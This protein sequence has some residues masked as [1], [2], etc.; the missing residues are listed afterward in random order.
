[1]FFTCS[2]SYSSQKMI[3]AH[4]KHKLWDS[5]TFCR[6]VVFKTVFWLL[7]IVFHFFNRKTTGSFLSE[8]YVSGSALSCFWLDKVLC[9]CS[10]VLTIIFRHHQVALNCFIE[11]QLVRC[12]YLRDKRK[13][14]ISSTSFIS[15]KIYHYSMIEPLKCSLN[16]RDTCIW[17]TLL[18]KF[19]RVQPSTFNILLFLLY[20]YINSPT[21]KKGT[22]EHIP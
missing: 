21:L 13:H 1:M 15:M 4:L 5:R 6:E 22:Y 9:F 17:E 12:I 7:L 14:K 11:I 19:N 10:Y 18:Q 20:P 3:N 8:F 16:L 2:V